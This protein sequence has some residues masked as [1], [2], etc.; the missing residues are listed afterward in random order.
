MGES[1]KVEATK[2]SGEKTIVYNQKIG[3]RSKK[4]SKQVRDE[5]FGRRHSLTWKKYNV[6]RLSHIFFSD[7]E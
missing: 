1:I 3:R 5:E 6:T 7:A 2:N 4:T